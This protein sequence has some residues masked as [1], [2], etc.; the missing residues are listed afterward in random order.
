MY[1]FIWRLLRLPDHYRENHKRSYRDHNGNRRRGFKHTK[2][3]HSYNVGTSSSTLY[4]H[5]TKIS[6][7]LLFAGRYL[8]W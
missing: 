3:V 4:D 7:T 5:Y 2:T 8:Y 6:G 1:R